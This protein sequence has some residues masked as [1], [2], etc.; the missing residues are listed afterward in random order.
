M[1][2]LQ[3]HCAPYGVIAT[4]KCSCSPVGAA[5][6]IL[7]GRGSVPLLVDNGMVVTAHILLSRWLFLGHF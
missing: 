3:F 6:S 5:P 1:V 2:V 4:V 7:G